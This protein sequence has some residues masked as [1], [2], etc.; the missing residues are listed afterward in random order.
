V[1]NE[2]WDNKHPGAISIYHPCSRILQTTGISED[3]SAGI[4]KSLDFKSQIV[5]HYSE[6]DYET[7][8][9]DDGILNDP[10]IVSKFIWEAEEH[11]EKH[12]SE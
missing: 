2:G 10:G 7:W 3:S 5:N 12:Q 6:N 1:N 9:G 4:Q 11:H 8:K